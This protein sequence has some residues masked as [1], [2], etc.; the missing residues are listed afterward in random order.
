MTHAGWQGKGGCPGCWSCGWVLQPCRAKP[1]STT[2]SAISCRSS[3][4]VDINIFPLLAAASLISHPQLGK[5]QS[6]LAEPQKAPFCCSFICANK[7][8]ILEGTYF[9]RRHLSHPRQLILLQLPTSS[10]CEIHV[11]RT[12]EERIREALFKH[13]RTRS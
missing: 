5:T 13:S 9:R 1:V 7:M 12:E 2:D 4:R 8:V 6:L 3:L 10:S 11:N